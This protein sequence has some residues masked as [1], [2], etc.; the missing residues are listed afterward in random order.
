[1]TGTRTMPMRKTNAMRRSGK[2]LAPFKRYLCLVCRET[3]ACR[4]Q[5]G[6]CIEGCPG[7]AVEEIK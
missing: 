1:M 7:F 5:P 2:P 6:K 3:M 4:S